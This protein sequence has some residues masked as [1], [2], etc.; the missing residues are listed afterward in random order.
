M[1]ASCGRSFFRRLARAARRQD[2]QQ[3]IGEIVEVAQTLAPE[4]IGLAQHARAGLVLHQIDCRLGGQ[5]VLD[6]LLEPAQP[7]A[8]VRKHAIGLEHVAVLAFACQ[9]FLA[10]QLVEG[11]LELLDGRLQPLRFSDRVLGLE[12]GD[13]DAR[14]VQHGMAERQSLRNR[15]RLDDVAER[16]G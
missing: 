8:I 13:H 11:D 3:A 15:L 7:A 2:A 14:L 12:L 5:P 16:R 6:G 10:K 4:R 1:I 9:R